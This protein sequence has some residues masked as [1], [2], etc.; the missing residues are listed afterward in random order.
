VQ[1]DFRQ[2]QH[3][4]EQCFPAAACNHGF[5]ASVHGPYGVAGA[6]GGMD[7]ED[8]RF[9][10]FGWVVADGQLAADRCAAPP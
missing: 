8:E 5:S 6:A 4:D 7:R 2:E 10:A 1:A 3:P 9:L